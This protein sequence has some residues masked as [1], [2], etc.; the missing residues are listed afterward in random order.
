MPF[1]KMYTFTIKICSVCCPSFEYGLK[2]KF[3]E[4]IFTF[5]P[6]FSPFPG[7]L[8]LTNCFYG[9]VLLFIVKVSFFEAL[10]LLSL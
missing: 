5:I 1:L 7:A 8:F 3:S 9:F 10:A 2:S 6:L 4:Q